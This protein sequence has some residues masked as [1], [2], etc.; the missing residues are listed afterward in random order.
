MGTKVIKTL[1][2]HALHQRFS[3]LHF[4]FHFAVI[5]AWCVTINTAV[6]EC[7]KEYSLDSFYIYI[8][9][10][11]NLLV[12]YLQAAKLTKKSSRNLATFS[13]R[14]F[15]LHFYVSG[16]AK[17]NMSP[18]YLRVKKPL[19]MANDPVFGMFERSNIAAKLRYS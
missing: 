3:F 12:L 10:G 5:L 18:Q 11:L 16:L 2:L 19:K 4:E 1:V 9:C 14:I 6:L 8:I 17:L 13:R 7:C 15:A